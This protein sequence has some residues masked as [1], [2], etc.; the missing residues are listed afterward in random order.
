MQEEVQELPEHNP[1][2][3]CPKCGKSFPIWRLHLFSGEKTKRP[4]HNFCPSSEAIPGR[5]VEICMECKTTEV[6]AKWKEL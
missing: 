3:I 4:A 1:E 2:Q 6:V 5:I